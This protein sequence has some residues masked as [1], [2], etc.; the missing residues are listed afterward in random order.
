MILNWFQRIWVH[1][2]HGQFVMI[3]M[4]RLLNWKLY[5][6]KDYKMTPRN[7]ASCLNLNNANK[8]LA[9]PRENNR[10]YSIEEP[11]FTMIHW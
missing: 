3:Y 11:S 10:V 2:E 8:I 5:K 7:A 6:M 9:K 4:R 1:W